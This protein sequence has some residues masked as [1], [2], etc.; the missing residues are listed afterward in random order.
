MAYCCQNLDKKLLYHQFYVQLITSDSPAIY[1]WKLEIS[2]RRQKCLFVYYT[3]II[4]LKS[5]VK[6]GGGLQDVLCYY[7][8]IKQMHY[9]LPNIIHKATQKSFLLFFVIT[10]TIIQC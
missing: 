3:R 6:G 1:E 4:L 7:Q 9:T 2:K 8:L 5:S 10:V